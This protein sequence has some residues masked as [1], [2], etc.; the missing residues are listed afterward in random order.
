MNGIRVVDYT[1]PSS[2]IICKACAIICT[3]LWSFVVTCMCR[4]CLSAI[5]RNVGVP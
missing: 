1:A 4:H 3:N 5:A 2:T